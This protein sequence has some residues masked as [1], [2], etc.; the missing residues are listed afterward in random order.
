MTL[1][2]AQHAARKIGGSDAALIMHGEHYGRNLHDLWL[3]KTGQ[4]EREDLSNVL[5]VQI[6]V[7]TEP[8]NRIW[9]ERETGNAVTLSETTYVHPDHDFMTA[10]VDGLI[11]PGVWE[12]KHIGAFS[13][14]DPV[15]SYFPQLQHYMAVLGVGEAHLSVIKGTDSWSHYIVPREDAYIATL[16]EREEAFWFCVQSET[17]PPGFEP[18]AAPIIE[19]TR[20]VDFTGNNQFA[21]CAADWLAN[22]DAAKAFEKATKEIK[23]LIEPDVSRAFGHGITVTRDKRGITVKEAA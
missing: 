2:T 12:A 5:R 13:K 16:I 4:K 23:A 6:G 14:A 19:A 10:H 9:Y 17:P 22:W 15:E 3:E 11:K 21:A 20:T 18:V 8:L 7:F 1:S